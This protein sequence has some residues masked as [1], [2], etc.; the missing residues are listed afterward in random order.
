MFAF[1]TLVPQNTIQKAIYLSIA[2]FVLIP[3][4]SKY[5]KQKQS[6]PGNIQNDTCPGGLCFCL[7]YLL[8]DESWRIA[9]TQKTMVIALTSV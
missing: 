7:R 5:R 3:S 4:L 2:L 9:L 6:P 1:C 8:S